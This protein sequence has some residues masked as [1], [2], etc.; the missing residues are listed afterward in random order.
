MKALLLDLDHTLYDYTVCNDEGNDAMLSAAARH[1]CRPRTEVEKAFHDARRAIKMR[2]GP[3]GA[4]HSRLLY[5][6]GLLERLTGRSQPALALL[7]HDVYWRRYGEMMRLFP[8]VRET[9][10]AVRANTI[11]IGIITDQ[12]V[13]VQLN[14]LVQLGIHDL[15]D[16][17]VT[18]E[19]AGV[20]KPDVRIFRLALEKAGCTAADCVYVGDDPERD[21]VGAA[22]AGIRF[23]DV[24]DAWATGL[25]GYLP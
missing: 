20:E 9:L 24:R 4:C 11:R 5:A 17:V 8:N 14:K 10:Q 22:A 7:L 2:L 12:L 25:R 23:V 13:H 18:S 3:V 6:Q 15:I 16:F 19:E 21:Q 1:L